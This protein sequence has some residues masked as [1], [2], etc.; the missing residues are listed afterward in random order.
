MQVCY[1]R[2]KYNGVELSVWEEE[3]G[4]KQRRIASVDVFFLDQLRRRRQAM[5]NWSA[6]GSQSPELARL[7]GRM[8][9]RAADLADTLNADNGRLL[10]DAAT[11]IEHV[12]KVADF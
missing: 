4:E 9:S 6:M 7:Y 1:E 8:L 12:V 11:G 5:V 2:Y 10:P 3:G